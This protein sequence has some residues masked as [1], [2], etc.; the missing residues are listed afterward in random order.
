MDICNFQIS[1]GL[2]KFP[3]RTK[4]HMFLE[5]YIQMNGIRKSNIRL[6]NDVHF[7]PKI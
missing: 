6:E 2:K 1:R 3:F 5:D 4:Y 7:G